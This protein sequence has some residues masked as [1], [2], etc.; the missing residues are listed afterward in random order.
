MK[1]LSTGFAYPIALLGLFAFAGCADTAD[2]SGPDTTAAQQSGLLL[3]GEIL[4]DLNGASS[5]QLIPN[6]NSYQTIS[7]TAGRERTSPDHNVVISIEGSE[8]EQ[9]DCDG[10]LRTLPVE[11]LVYVNGQRSG[12]VVSSG[13]PSGQNDAHF[14]YSNRR[15]SAGAFQMSAITAFYPARVL[16]F[17]PQGLYGQHLYETVWTPK[18]G[19]YTLP[20]PVAVEVTHQYVDS[21][22]I[23][24]TAGPQRTSGREVRGVWSAQE[25]SSGRVTVRDVVSGSSSSASFTIPIHVDPPLEGPCVIRNGVRICA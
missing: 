11:Y 15:W 21:A 12:L 10:P 3:P 8:D 1:R 7:C 4:L 25:G 5:V 22:G 13:P 6:I 18:W 19:G 24:R 16:N 17:S 2:L 14:V 9:S 23:M 20:G